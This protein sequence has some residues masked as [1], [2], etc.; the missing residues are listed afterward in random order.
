M[1]ECVNR[2]A[3]N[4]THACVSEWLSEQT[5]E[6]QNELINES[7]HEWNEWM[8]WWMM[9]SINERSHALRNTLFL[10]MSEFGIEYIF[11]TLNVYICYLSNMNAYLCACWFDDNWCVYTPF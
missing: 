3:S 7:N 5:N 10:W 6:C 2:L 8:N 1:C 4:H 11:D 9:D